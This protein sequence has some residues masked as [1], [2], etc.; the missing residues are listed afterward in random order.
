MHVPGG[1]LCVF[2]NVRVACPNCIL[3]LVE[4]NAIDV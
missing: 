4:Y 1:G 3:F 2:V